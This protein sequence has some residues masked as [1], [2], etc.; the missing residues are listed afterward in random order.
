MFIVKHV[1]YAKYLLRHKWFVALECFKE[2]L[3]WMGIIHDWSKFLPSEFFPYAN[4]FYSDRVRGSTG[5]YK[6]TD[7]GNAEFDF[8][9]LLHQK[10]NDHH[11]QWWVLPEDGGGMKVLRMPQDVLTEMVCDWCGASR[12]QGFNGKSDT[13]EWYKTYKGK[14]SLHPQTREMVEIILLD[15]VGITDSTAVLEEQSL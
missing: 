13:I 9:W 8:A 5:Y 15:H 1:K 3:I 6:P 7:T 4:F 10:R 14:M 2:G 12:A 11:W